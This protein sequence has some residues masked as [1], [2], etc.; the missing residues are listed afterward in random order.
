MARDAEASIRKNSL[1]QSA[2]K[3]EVKLPGDFKAPQGVNFEFSKDDPLL[4][5][6]RELA[7]QRGLS[8]EEFSDFLGVYAASKIGEGQQLQVARDA[9]KALLG[10][11]AD[12]RIA[13]VET[14]LKARVG[15]KAEGIVAQ[16]KNF[17]VAA[18]VEA[19]EEIARQFSHQGGAGYSQSGRTDPEPAPTI[20][21]F[22]GTNFTQVRAAQ[23]AAR[24]KSAGGR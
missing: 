13:A 18:Y 10:S 19:F 22:D 1:P 3:Y 5:R 16:L 7:H 24:Q 23:D 8:Q 4:A 9:Q 17:P 2:D 20:P 15:N 21:A 14:W 6:A 12:N 11:A